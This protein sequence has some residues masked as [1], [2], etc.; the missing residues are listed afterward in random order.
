MPPSAGECDEGCSDCGLAVFQAGGT[1]NDP[2]LPDPTGGTTSDTAGLDTARDDPY[3]RWHRPQPGTGV[4]E[5]GISLRRQQPTMHAL[6]MIEQE[7]G[8]GILTRRG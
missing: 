3:A 6:P 2:A 7:Y 5:P 8:S 1:D 4:S